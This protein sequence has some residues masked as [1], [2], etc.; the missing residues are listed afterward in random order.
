MV[1]GNPGEKYEGTRHNVGFETIDMIAEK[2][3][4]VMNKEKFN[5]IF[6]E[7]LYNG[8][9]VML[10]KPMTYMNLSG[11]SVC[12]IVD[13][14]KIPLSDLIVI[15]DD[16]DIEVGKIRIRPEGSSGT[17][18]GMRNISDML[19]SHDFPRIRIGTGKPNEGVD[20]ADYV[21]GKFPNEEKVEIKKS[22]EMAADAVLD[23]L[24][25]GIEKAMNTYN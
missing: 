15:Y 12:E 23:I 8:K 5:G 17:H 11:E 3:N 20:L 1:Y 2:L 21:L 24:D 6:G 13:F 16:I 9:K 7:G 18:N 4:I 14:Y 25:S 22:I 19:G 10:L